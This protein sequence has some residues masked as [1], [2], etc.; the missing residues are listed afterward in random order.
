[1]GNDVVNHVIYYDGDDGVVVYG[2]KIHLN[3]IY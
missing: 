1:M 2:R 3:N